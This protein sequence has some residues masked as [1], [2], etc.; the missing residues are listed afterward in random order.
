MR[1]SY[2]HNDNQTLTND[3]GGKEIRGF[4]SHLRWTA[5]EAI[6]A[7]T[8]GVHLAYACTTPAVSATCTVAA[9]TAVTD[10]LT[11]TAPST[12]G[13]T[14]NAL[15]ILLTTA[16]DD[17]L[18]VTKDDETSTI[19]ISLAKTS[20][21]KNTAT[22]VQ[23]AIRSLTTVG[24]VSVAL[25]TCTAGGNWNSE[26]V[27]TGEAEAVSFTSGQTATA[28]IL[29]DDILDLPCGRNITATAGGTSGDIKAVQVI[30]EGTNINDETISETLPIF[31]ADTTGTVVGSKIF[32]T[33]TKI[34]I[35]A[36]D[37]TGATT[38]IGFGDIL[39][40]P[41]LLEHN[42]VLRACLNNV[43]E[44]TAPTVTASATVIESNS[45]D[46]YSSLDGH[47]V[48]IYLIV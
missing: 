2:K 4:I 21:N 43:A 8:D 7:D 40:I 24:G 3:I 1:E 25:F 9:L 26:A 34:T 6:A 11:V 39:G 29:E 30:V 46:L 15:S 44:T 12:L 27:A 42:T 47:I 35:P 22:L 16:G 41:Y 28:D 20:A 13:D 48:D 38:A 45:V 10:I 17:V 33:V 37:G 23:A 31:S 36:M 14:A 19:N 5:L 18:A 32:K